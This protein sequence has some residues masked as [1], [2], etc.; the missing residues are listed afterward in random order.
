MI[1]G[2]GQ[3]DSIWMAAARCRDLEPAMF[4]PSDGLGVELARRICVNCPVQAPCL[5]YALQHH[6]EHGV[7]GGTSERE[8]RRIAR[9]RRSVPHTSM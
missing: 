8:R 1:G 6:I 4:F 2:D 9:R 7:W 3:T 5:E